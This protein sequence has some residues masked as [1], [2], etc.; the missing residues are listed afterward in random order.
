[1][2]IFFFSKILPSMAI[3]Y[4]PSYQPHVHKKKRV[5]RHSNGHFLLVK[6]KDCEETNVC[7]SHSQ[8]SIKCKGCSG[9][10]LK[11]T[12]GKAQLTNKAKAK[13]AESAY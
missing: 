1:M 8:T 3:S 2:Q 13:K 9:L 12:G 7:Y 6:C 4:L 5:F 10:I 11:S